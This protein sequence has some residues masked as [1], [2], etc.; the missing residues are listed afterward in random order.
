MLFT[1][2]QAST[3]YPLIQ[4]ILPREFLIL[5]LHP[6]LRLFGWFKSA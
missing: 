3:N 2:Q 4:P 5:D 6:E 1:F